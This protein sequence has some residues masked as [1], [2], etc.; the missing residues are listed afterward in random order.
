MNALLF[1]PPV[2]T[3][4]RPS[5]DAVVSFTGYIDIRSTIKYSAW[6]N[7]TLPYVHWI[8][9]RKKR[10]RTF[11]ILLLW[12]CRVRTLGNLWCLRHRLTECGIPHLP[13][14]HIQV[15]LGEHINV[16]GGNEQFVNAAKIIKNPTFQRKNLNN[17]I[18]LIKLSSPVN[19]NARVATVALPSSCAPAST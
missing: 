7:F 14:S 2:G 9:L 4:K 5:N 17:D 1:L 15:R 13:N 6:Q 19:L 12:C 10:K 11:L 16:L 3:S 8:S 18:M